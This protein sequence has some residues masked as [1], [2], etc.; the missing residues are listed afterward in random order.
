[1]MLN[2]HR[3]VL[4][5][6]IIEYLAIKPNGIYIDATLG[7][8]GHSRE[9]LNRLDQNGFLLAIDRD[10]EAINFAKQHLK[11][12]RQFHIRQGSF[13]MLHLFVNEFGLDQKVNGILLDLGVSSPQLDDPERGFSFVQD[14]PLDMRMDASQSCDAATWINQANE[15]EIAEVLW[16][17]GEERYARR[18]ANAIIR[19][20]KKERIIRTKHLSDIIAR[21][22]PA[23]E[24]HKHPARRSFQ[25]IRIHINHELEELD[26]CLDQSFSF[27]AVGGRLI[28]VSYHSLE[29]RI[30]KE[31]IQTKQHGEFPRDLP[32]TKDQLTPK[33]KRIAW[34]V[35]ATDAE[36]SENPR[37]RSAILRVVEKLQ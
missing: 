35:R 34:G 10:S 13:S 32:L 22:N 3:P 8:G 30:V 14:G 15:A 28:V 21:A 4:L 26:A 33:L 24:R 18:I 17:Y 12:H 20:R 7:R 25:A 36:V 23:W 1:M 31:F 29:D 2:Y 16:K 9:I 5:P 6:E 11:G 27:L 19:E 37:S